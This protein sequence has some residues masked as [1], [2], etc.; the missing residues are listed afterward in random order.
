MVGAYPGISRDCHANVVPGLNEWV[1]APIDR[2]PS[3]REFAKLIGVSTAGLNSIDQ[4]MRFA[5]ANDSIAQLLLKRK[6]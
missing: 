3:A 5:I 1:L 4:E 6:S 2:V